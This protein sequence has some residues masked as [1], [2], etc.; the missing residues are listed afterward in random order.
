VFPKRSARSWWFTL[1]F[2][3]ISLLA[4]AIAAMSSAT[5]RMGLA[6]SYDNLLRL[7]VIAHS[8]D[9]KEQSAKLAVRDALVAEMAAWPRPSGRDELESTLLANRERLEEVAE[10]ALRRAGVSHE[11]RVEIGEYAFPDKQSG[12]I[13]LPAGQYRAVRV[14][15][16]DGQGRN[17]W[18]VLF[19]P[20]C[21]I[22]DEVTGSEAEVGA[23]SGAEPRLAPFGRLAWVA[24]AN[25]PENAGPAQE[26]LSAEAGGEWAAAPIVWRLRLWE[27]L[28]GSSYAGAIRDL[29]HVAARK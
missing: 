6:H 28:G 18:C 9:P 17:W 12:S 19:P 8:D 16:G 26:R 4:A 23:E 21:F 29:L 27:V 14:V 2:I 10:A 5:T 7:H 24:E 25:A 13:F 3:G 20:L 1:G 11:V 15:I 22:G